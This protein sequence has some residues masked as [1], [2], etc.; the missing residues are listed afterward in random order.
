MPTSRRVA[1]AGRLLNIPL[2]D[3]LIVGGGTGKTYSFREHEPERFPR[4]VPYPYAGDSGMSA[5]AIPK[6]DTGLLR[7]EVQVD[8]AQKKLSPE[9]ACGPERG[10]AILHDRLAEAGEDGICFAGLDFHGYP[11]HTLCAPVRSVSRSYF[12]I[13]AFFKDALLH[14]DTFCMAYHEE[15]PN[16]PVCGEDYIA[17]KRLAEAGRLAGIPLLDFVVWDEFGTMRGSRG[18]YPKLFKSTKRVNYR[19][20]ATMAAE[21]DCL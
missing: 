5:A 14:N 18:D 13:G 2:M 4:T 1:E 6:K 3:H 7:V 20:L 11:V 19:Y 12:T 8:L 10:I 16:G 9:S 21:P 17:M 15:G